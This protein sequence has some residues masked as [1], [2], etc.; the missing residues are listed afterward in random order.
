MLKFF[1]TIRK[2]L[3]EQNNVRT[4]LL[5]A[6]GE[7]FLVVIGILIALQVNNLNEKR[8][9][10]NF[11]QDILYLIDQNLQRDSVRLAE[12]LFETEQ[13]IEYTDHLIAQVE[14]DRFEEVLHPRG[15]PELVGLAAG[16]DPQH[17]EQRG[18][19]QPRHKLRRAQP[20][21]R[22][23]VIGIGRHTLR[24][25][26]ET[27]LSDVGDQRDQHQHEEDRQQRLRQADRHRRPGGQRQLR[28]S[29]SDCRLGELLDGEPTEK[30]GDLAPGVH[31]G[32][33]CGQQHD[34]A[35]QV[36]AA[37]DLPFLAGLLPAM[38]CGFMLL[39]AKLLGH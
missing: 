30:N 17:Q 19:G 39:F 10:Q 33:Q 9:A 18:R 21:E 6:I 31:Q 36:V 14:H 2:K 25:E 26:Q 3:I 38:R 37:R 24:H 16:E 20:L 22:V 5:Y 7:V 27:G 23:D 15:G 32:D 4:Y 28:V 8:K 29:V 35:G 34:G 1:R 11:E 13:G 12:V